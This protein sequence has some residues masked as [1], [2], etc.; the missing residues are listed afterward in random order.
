MN[1]KNRLISRLGKQDR[2]RLLALGKIACLVQGEMLFERGESARYVYF[3]MSGAV[4]LQVPS[5]PSR[6]LSIL[7][8]GREGMLG[9]QRVLGDS[10]SPLRAVVQIPG[11]TLRIEATD[12]TQ[13]LG[14]SP[15]LR[16]AMFSYVSSAMNQM[17]IA[18]GCARHHDIEPRLA[19]WLLMSREKGA[20]DHLQITQL[21][22]SLVLGVR[23][24][25]VTLAAGKLKRL[26]LIDYCRGN[27]TIVDAA[28][29]QTVA[30]QSHRHPRSESSKSWLGGKFDAIDALTAFAEPV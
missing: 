15:L 3:P 27:I 5:C 11:E 24:V 4:A 19:G 25:S 10:L 30:G 18:M 8:V 16:A 9:V 6:A 14:G 28:G 26:Q 1:H 2:A 29:L 22:L 23:R 20:S 21:A 13:L 7:L 12:F 17:V